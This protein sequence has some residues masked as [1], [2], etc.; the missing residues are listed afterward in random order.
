[1]K[2]VLQRVSSASVRIGDEIVGKIN[3]GYLV[4][5]GF[6]IN[7]EKADVDRIIEKIKKL[8]LF[9]DENG[10]T[11][12]SINEIDGELLIVS[13]FTLYAD[14]NQGNRPSFTDAATPSSAKDLYN[15]FVAASKPYFAKVAS[16][17]FGASMEVELI[18]DGP[19]TV[20]LEI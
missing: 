7:D 16:G 8:R 9:S 11:N 2:I 5:V 6:G 12:R 14:C 10:K 17:C 1:M 19:F 13:Q 20:I 4:F 18:N 15:Y 3:Y